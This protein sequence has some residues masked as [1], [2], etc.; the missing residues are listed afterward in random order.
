MTSLNLNLS[1]RDASPKPRRVSGAQKLQRV[2][3]GVHASLSKLEASTDRLAE[4]KALAEASRYLVAPPAE[5]QAVRDRAAFD[6][7]YADRNERQR[8]QLRDTQAKADAFFGR[9]GR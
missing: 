9:A 5:V 6:Q 3:N 4:K 7:A 8:Q 2:L 1:T